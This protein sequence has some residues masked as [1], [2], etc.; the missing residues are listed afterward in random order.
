MFTVKKKMETLF[1]LAVV[2][3]FLTTIYTTV[4]VNQGMKAKEKI[5]FIYTYLKSA[6]NS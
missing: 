3:L 2:G 1:W 5:N 6:S 4:I